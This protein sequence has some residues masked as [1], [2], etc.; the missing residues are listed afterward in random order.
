MQMPKIHQFLIHILII[1]A[2]TQVVPYTVGSGIN[3]F[4][5]ESANL[6]YHQ[7]SNQP[8]YLHYFQ[9]CLQQYTPIS[10]SPY[11]LFQQNPIPYLWPF[12]PCP[13]QQSSG[14]IPPVQEPSQRVGGSVMVYQLIFR[15]PFTWTFNCFCDCEEN[16]LYVPRIPGQ[17]M[18]FMDA[19]A[20]VKAQLREAVRE[21]F[22][23]IGVAPEGLII[24]TS[25]WP[26]P[27]FIVN[28][29][30]IAKA[31]YIKGKYF[32]TLSKNTLEL[33]CEA[34][35]IATCV[36]KENFRTFQETATLTID[37]LNVLSQSQRQQLGIAIQRSLENRYV[38]FTTPIQLLEDRNILYL[39]P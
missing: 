11:N 38:V 7:F 36:K 17:H 24:T 19:D 33:R 15:P 8:T 12:K 21:A 39:D 1:I 5:I 34:R 28:D 3:H 2:V 26:Y 4:N 22:R 31:T 37:V 13:D 20:Y 25:F 9:P 6:P 29:I 18:N 10:L 30:N 16:T 27:A 14:N 32:Y 35:E 23:S